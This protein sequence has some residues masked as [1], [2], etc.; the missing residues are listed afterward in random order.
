MAV[1]KTAKG[2][3]RTIGIADFNPVPDEKVSNKGYTSL[4]ITNKRK[5]ILKGKEYPLTAFPYPLKTSD[6][7]N[8]DYDIV[9]SSSNKKV[10]TVVDG[11]IIAKKAGKATI[12]AKLRGTKIKDSFTIQ[13]KNPPST[14]KKVYNV[15]ADFKSSE[16]YTT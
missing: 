9:W 8:S 16:G 10:A 6:S 13:V 1:I 15:P 3:T 12:T 5:T 4:H 7:S 2:E 14:K 11:L